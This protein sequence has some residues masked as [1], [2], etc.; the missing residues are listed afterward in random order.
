MN[1]VTAEPGVPA[2]VRVAL[3][4]NLVGAAYEL[5]RE[6]RWRGVDA[7]LLLSRREA[8]T[9]REN[10]SPEDFGERR[11]DLSWVHV[12]D[13]PSGDDVTPASSR[14]RE[15]FGYLRHTPRLWRTLRSFDVVHAFTLMPIFAA[16]AGPPFI[17]TP[18]GSDARE[19]APSLGLLGYLLRRAYRRT[20]RI[21]TPA[22][23]EPIRQLLD[24]VGCLERVTF[25]P[26]GM[27][28]PDLEG[29]AS[30]PQ[31]T[32]Q[33]LH[34]LSLGRWHFITT[35]SEQAHKGNDRFLDAAA[36]VRAEGIPLRLTLVE[37]G[38]DLEAARRLVRDLG[39]EDIVTWVPPMGRSQVISILRRH[40]VVAD[41][42]QY[43]L[44]GGACLEPMTS[45][46]PVLIHISPKAEAEAY[47]EPMPVLNVSSI[48]EIADAMRYAHFHRAELRDLG[49]RARAFVDRYH[50]WDTVC[51]QMAHLY[52]EVA[53][54]RGP[55]CR[56]AEAT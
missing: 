23:D 51:A 55:R 31:S 30:I 50:S 53:A 13:V 16:D 19:T 2:P 34:Y 3:L 18:T 17:A 7:H 43:G 48:E 47:P 26:W 54:R 46:L 44:W 42:F 10:T 20:A 38:Q 28:Q 29:G 6:L 1:N 8:T 4:G 14:I 40:H 32:D 24:R 25:V 45:A 35:D 22:L 33:P 41:H 12:W 39:L 27:D 36:K 15:R 56:G 21:V 9:R 52:R 5:A 49:M 37:R 11:Q